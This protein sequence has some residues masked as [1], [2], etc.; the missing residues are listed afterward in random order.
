MLAVIH[1]LGEHGPT[2]PFPYSSKLRHKLRE[3]RTSHGGEQYRVLY[4]GAPNRRFVL[5]HALSKHSAQV[6]ERDIAI[7][8]ARMEE[9]LRITRKGPRSDR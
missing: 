7:A 4:F 1:R 5:L 9:Y 2:L 3:L 8:Q 6:P